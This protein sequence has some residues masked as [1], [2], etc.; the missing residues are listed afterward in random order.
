MPDLPKFAKDARLLAP[1]RPSITGRVVV[2]VG[3]T[4]AS[5]GLLASPVARADAPRAATVVHVSSP[6]TGSRVGPLVLTPPEGLDILAQHRSHASH[7]SHASHYSSSTGSLPP[8]TAPSAAKSSSSAPADKPPAD[9]STEKANSTT[10]TDKQ[11]TGPAQSGSGR[12]TTVDKAATPPSAHAAVTVTSLPALAEIEVDGK[13]M[14]NTRSSL[15]LAPGT[16]QVT[17]KRDGYLPWTKTIEVTAD[18]EL[19]VHADLH[20]DRSATTKKT[21]T[22]KK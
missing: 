21:P 13:Y 2:L 16:H 7:A 3:T 20:T 15:R 17:I 22:P 9:T 8:A 11:S 10:S 19:A 1:K 12:T 14:G 6:A 18:S 4:L 5:L